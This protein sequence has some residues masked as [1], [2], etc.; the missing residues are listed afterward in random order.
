MSGDPPYLSLVLACYNE[1]EHLRESFAE[2]RDTLEGAGWPFEVVFVDDV[3]GDGTP[4]ILDEIVA[5][6]SQLALRVI[7]HEKNRGRGA[8]VT[9]GFRAARGEITGYL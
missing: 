6:H 2:I 8:T 5:A 7:R 9:Y 4:E 3:S 1:A